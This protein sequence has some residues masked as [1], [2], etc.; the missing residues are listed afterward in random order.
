V[1]VPTVSKHPNARTYESL[2]RLLVADLRDYAIF[3]MDTRGKLTSWNAG[4]ER[5]LGYKEDEFIGSHVSRLFTDEDVRTKQ[6]EQEMET[7][8][9]SGRAP[10]QRWHKRKDGRLIWVDGVVTALRDES[11][12]LLGFSKVMRDATARKNA[13]DRLIQMQDRFS[14]LI[15]SI[16]EVFVAVDREWRITWM[17][18]RAA[19]ETGLQQDAAGQVIWEVVP[20]L[21]GTEVEAVCRR[22]MQERRAVNFE[23]FC[24]QRQQWFEI[25]VQP[26]STGLSALVLNA[27][28]RKQ[29]E[30]KLRETARLESLGLLAGGIAHDFN[31]LLTGVLGGASFLMHKLPPGND[32][33]RSMAEV[34]SRS[35]EKAAELTG[36]MLAYSGRGRFVLAVV[37]VNEQIREMLPLVMTAISRS[38]TIDLQLKPDLP[39]IEV[40]PSQT[41]QVILNLLINASEA[42]DGNPG[43]IRVATDV[44]DCSEADLAQ[45]EVRADDIRPGR[46]VC[47]EVTDTGAG[48]D[49]ATKSRIFDPFFTTKFTGRGLG[50]AAVMGIVRGHHGAISVKSS[51]GTGS[52][53]TVCFPALAESAPGRLRK[54]QE[55]KKPVSASGRDGLT[56]LVADDEQAV[57]DIARAM[58]ESAGHNVLTAVNGQEAVDV[59][60]HHAEQ[61]DLVLL[62]MT[63]PVLGGEGALR[64]L[65]S[66]R[67]DIRVI[68]SSGY[69]EEEARYRFGQG[70]TG[71][72]QKPYSIDQLLNAV[73]TATAQ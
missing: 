51:P 4:V 30:Q 28:E 3:M 26:T 15:N 11:G 59:F 48:M 10:D 36:Q 42:M 72:L 55:T 6:P 7:A 41:Q 5:I 46:Y 13:E 19:E 45:S 35:A 29:L 40:D 67:P 31:N 65:R 73:A 27:T 23:T 49:A 32:D 34:I 61:V 1:D 24:E 38:V 58:L 22:A 64:Q 18:R 43:S 25:H 33:V 20:D 70:L 57:R 2:Y 44:R 62:D 63:M 39:S 69:T 17:N 54:R 50:L 52:R 66:I 53:F 8:A 14:D 16:T 56:V 68:A 9:Q 47:I 21:A 37:D 60:R 12:E 71:F